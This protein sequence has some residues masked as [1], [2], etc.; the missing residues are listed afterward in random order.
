M[1][2]VEF[3]ALAETV[4]AQTGIRVVGRYA[5]WVLISAFWLFVVFIFRWWAKVMFCDVGEK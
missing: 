5:F 2:V 4:E 1:Y 3:E